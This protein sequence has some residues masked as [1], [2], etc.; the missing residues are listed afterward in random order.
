MLNP[1]DFKEGE[2]EVATTVI[3][4]GVGSIKISHHLL[5]KRFKKIAEVVSLSCTT[6][7]DQLK[8]EPFIYVGI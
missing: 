1:L 7:R 8:G 3:L 2:A 4:G 5:E 6:F